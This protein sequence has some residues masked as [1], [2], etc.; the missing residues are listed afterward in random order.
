LAVPLP[1]PSRSSVIVAT[2]DV[3]MERHVCERQ[4]LSHSIRPVRR[5]NLPRVKCALIESE[6]WRRF[7]VDV[8]RGTLRR[9]RSLRRSYHAGEYVRRSQPRMEHTVC[10]SVPRGT[11][12]KSEE[13]LSSHHVPRETPCNLRRILILSARLG[14]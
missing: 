6:S 2:A 10:L 4:Y 1:K 11:L 7:A 14:D 13:I 8:P 12:A 9:E 3:D 5:G